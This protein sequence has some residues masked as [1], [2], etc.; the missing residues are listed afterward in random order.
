MNTETII[1]NLT[2]DIKNSCRDAI[3]NQWGNDKSNRNILE[4]RVNVLLKKYI[5]KNELEDGLYIKMDGEGSNV[6]LRFYYKDRELY[7]ESME[8]LANFNPYDYKYINERGMIKNCETSPVE[9]T[10]TLVLDEN[11][12]SNNHE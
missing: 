4:Q 9:F 5:A 7:L 3:D 10:F 12:E 2:D 1:K 6:I 11:E 8:Q